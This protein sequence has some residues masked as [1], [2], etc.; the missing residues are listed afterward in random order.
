MVGH[1]SRADGCGTFRKPESRLRAG[2]R[3][4]PERRG[5]GSEAP[6]IYMCVVPRAALSKP[7]CIC[8]GERV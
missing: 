5:G 1:C 7:A 8:R 2:L 6:F 4:S 3:S